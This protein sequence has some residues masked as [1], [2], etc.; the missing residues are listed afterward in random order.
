MRLLPWL[1][2][3]ILV[4]AVLLVAGH[5]MLPYIAP[6]EGSSTPPLS[7]VILQPPPDEH[8]EDEPDEPELDGQLVEVS[9]PE[10]EEIPEDADYLADHNQKVEEETKAD[11]TKVN[12]EILARVFSKEE[13]LQQESA[14]DVNAHMPSTG[15]TPGNDR[16]DPDQHGT[17]ASLPHPWVVTNREGVQDPVMASHESSQLSGAPQNDWLDLKRD[18]ELSINSKEYLYNSYIQRIRRLVNFYWNQNLDN[19]PHSVRLPGSHYVTEVDVV[20]NSDG[21]LELIEVVKEAGVGELD[22]CVVRAFKV[23]GPFPNPP[24][25]LVEADGRVYLPHMAWRVNMS[26]ARVSYQGIDPRAGVQFPGILKSPR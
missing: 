12:P 20:L 23:A 3:S 10:E 15:A 4:N 5:F 7:L 22:D 21:A 6:A 11:R 25:G 2:A 18:S 16:F 9:P 26:A 13:K 8:V 1:C 17:L 24:A 14:V 19:L